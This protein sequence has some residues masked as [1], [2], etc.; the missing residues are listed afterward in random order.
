MLNNCIHTISGDYKQNLCH[1]GDFNCKPCSERLPSCIGLGDGPKPHSSRLWGSEYIVCGQNRTITIDRCS[2]GYF[3]PRTF[4]CTLTI[5]KGKA[6]WQV[7]YISILYSF[8]DL[9]IFYC[10]IYKIGLNTSFITYIN[11]V[12]GRE[13]EKVNE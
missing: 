11:I 6:I 12:H 2:Q 10:Q 3:N 7:T 9:D 5:L 13:F 1:A 4:V 8:F